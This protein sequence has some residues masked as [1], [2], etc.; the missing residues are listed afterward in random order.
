MIIHYITTQL[1]FS[2]EINE[3][4]SALLWSQ[5]SSVLSLE[6]NKWIS[7]TVRREEFCLFPFLSCKINPAA[8]SMFFSPFFLFFEHKFVFSSP[9]KNS[10]SSCPP[11]PIKYRQHHH[12]IKLLSFFNHYL[13]FAKSLIYSSADALA[14]A[15]L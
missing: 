7:H 12:N 15:L 4:F 11:L 8:W 3:R 14:D 1:H 5:I 13:L 2:C 10:P 6:L 9:K